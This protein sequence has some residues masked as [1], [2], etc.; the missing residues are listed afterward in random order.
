VRDIVKR[1]F[2][3]ITER[4]IR[5]RMFHS[6]G[7]LVKPSTNGLP[8]GMAPGPFAWNASADVNLDKVNRCKEVTGTGD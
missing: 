1:V 4:M 8:T 7:E 5:R 3:L 6:A 2:A